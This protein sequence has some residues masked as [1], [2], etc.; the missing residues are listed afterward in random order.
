MFKRILIET[1]KY[2]RDL[3]LKY[4][5]EGHNFV[6]PS[7]VLFCALA[8]LYVLSPID[9]I[10][11]KWLPWYLAYWDD[12]FVAGVAL[13]RAISDISDVQL[14]LSLLPRRDKEDEFVEPEPE[15]PEELP[16]DVQA[17][18]DSFGTAGREEYGDTYE[19]KQGDV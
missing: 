17:A 1:L 15:E 9:L 16:Q 19:Q 18:L 7:T 10:P 5:A 3:T 13:A 6:R 14:S 11:E 2:E 12:L 8:L 4:R